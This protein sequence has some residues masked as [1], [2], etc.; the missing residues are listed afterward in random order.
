M[1]ASHCVLAITVVL[2]VPLYFPLLSLMRSTLSAIFDVVPYRFAESWP[3]RPASMGTL[4]CLA[5][6]YYNEMRR[7]GSLLDV[8]FQFKRRIQ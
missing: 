6:Y 1:V 5:P 3:S 4:R 7:D 2:L 8:S